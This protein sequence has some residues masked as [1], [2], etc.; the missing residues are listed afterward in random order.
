MSFVL[1]KLIDYV[2]CLLLCNLFV[3]CFDLSVVLVSVSILKISDKLKHKN[4]LARRA[5]ELSIS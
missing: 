4:E 2:I 1:F 5:H 3:I